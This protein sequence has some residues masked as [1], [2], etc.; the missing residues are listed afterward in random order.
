MAKHAE[1][2]HNTIT[3]N[4][5]VQLQNLSV[6]YGDTHALS[7]VNLTVQEGDFLGI[8]GPNGGGKTT[9]LKAILGLLTPSA[10]TV[11]LFGS[12]PRQTRTR[13]G[14]VPQVNHLNRNF[15][16]NV[17]DL[18]LMGKLPGRPAPFY[19]FS[20][21]DRQEVLDILEKTG[22]DGLKKRQVAQ[23]SG[24]EFQKA[25]IARA[26]AVNPQ[27]LV[28]DEPTA[29]VDTRS[30]EQIFNLLRE[31]NR[32]ITIILVTHDLSVISSHVLSL[33]CLNGTLFYHGEPILNQKII[34]ELYGCPV[35]LIAHGVPHRVLRS[36]E[37][38]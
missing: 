23:L 22:L 35:E 16:I 5:P 7:R 32:E 34:G 13:V 12:P 33:A 18:V 37:G 30:H 11:L 36:H 8:I 38:E 20:R 25:L 4:P 10:G 6:Q 24:G 26:L 31:L 9:L 1:T 28:L 2:Y 3:E 15:P 27:L 21:Q 29:S 19:R 17:Q 14:Y